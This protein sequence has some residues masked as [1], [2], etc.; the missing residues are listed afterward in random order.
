MHFSRRLMLSLFGGIT[1]V[2]M[3][4]ALYQVIAETHALKDE[5]QRQELILAQ[6]QQAPV[7]QALQRGSRAEL[8]TIVDQFRDHERLAGM[9]IYDSRV[10]LWRLRPVSRRA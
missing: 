6:S 5:V 4:F 2:S 7:E 3:A 9:A 10:S 8:Q 1:V